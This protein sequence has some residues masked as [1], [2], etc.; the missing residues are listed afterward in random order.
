M[1]TLSQR[2]TTTCNPGA[3]LLTMVLGVCF[4]IVSSA[5]WAVFTHVIYAIA[6]PGVASPFIGLELYIAVAGGLLLSSVAVV[7]AAVALSLIG[8]RLELSRF[9]QGG[10]AGAGAALAGLGLFI[11][12]GS[13]IVLD[14][15]EI[16]GILAF[17]VAASFALMCVR[18]SA[19]TSPS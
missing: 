7:G 19:H 8:H 11:F 18:A 2:Q 12:L 1:G 5:I 6:N 10:I 15:R 16:A 13:T 3:V 4:G 17:V 14:G 9:A